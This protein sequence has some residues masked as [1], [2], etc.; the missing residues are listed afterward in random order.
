LLPE[1]R[2]IGPCSERKRLKTS[3]FKNGIQ[4]AIKRLPVIIRLLDKVPGSQENAETRQEHPPRSGP[5]T[6]EIPV[7]GFCERH[8]GNNHRPH[9]QL[10]GQ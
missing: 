8:G 9:I 1:F 7:G 10:G 3:I 6:R 2:K 4:I 5:D